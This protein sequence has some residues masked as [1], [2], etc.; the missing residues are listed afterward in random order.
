M[1]SGGGEK[2]LPLA[3][4]QLLLRGATLR[5]TPWIHGI[6]VFT[7]HET[8]LMRNATAT[9]IK[10]TAVERMVNL[11]VL[12]LVTILVVLSLISSVGDLI[13]RS[14]AK[15]KLRYLIIAN[16]NAGKQ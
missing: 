2:E 12:M 13:V 16:T 14:T 1:H 6:V 15:S 4:D 3:P 7:G 11:Q 5:N 8:K 9:P 10:Q